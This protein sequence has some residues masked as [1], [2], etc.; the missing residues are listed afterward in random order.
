MA[1]RLR[2]SIATFKGKVPWV[3]DK[4]GRNWVLQPQHLRDVW[5]PEDFRTDSEMQLRIAVDDPAFCLDAQEDLRALVHHLQQ[6]LEAIET[7]RVRAS[8]FPADPLNARQT[9]RW[10]PRWRVPTWRGV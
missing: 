6:G 10:P 3:I 1:A 5:D 7:P 4:A 8:P 9:P 2:D